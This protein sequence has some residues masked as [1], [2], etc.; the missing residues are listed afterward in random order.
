MAMWTALFIFLLIGSLV[1]TVK[2]FHM[3][4]ESTEPLPEPEAESESAPSLPVYGT[5]TNGAVITASGDGPV[6][7]T[8][9][10]IGAFAF[11][12]ANSAAYMTTY[13]PVGGSQQNTPPTIDSLPTEDPGIP[14]Q[15]WNDNGEIK[16]SGER[17]AF[18]DPPP[19]ASSGNRALDI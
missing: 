6:G 13:G 3:N 17:G 8:A 7:I 12:Y 15:L 18:D 11:G 4:I 5:H 14:G 1:Y 10:G 9:S 2:R 19:F 16:Q